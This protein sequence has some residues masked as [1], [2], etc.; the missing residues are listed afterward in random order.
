M[1]QAVVGVPVLNMIKL[2]AGLIQ[3]ETPDVH[4]VG[5][6]ERHPNLRQTD[7]VLDFMCDMRIPLVSNILPLEYTKILENFNKFLLTI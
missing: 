7:D 3:Q 4:T 2:A 6:L 5:L 1:V